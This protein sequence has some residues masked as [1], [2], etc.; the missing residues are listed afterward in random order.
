MTIDPEVI[1]QLNQPH[2]EERSEW[3]ISQLLL[4]LDVLGG[5]TDEL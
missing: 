1:A 4:K 3:E 2:K 5:I